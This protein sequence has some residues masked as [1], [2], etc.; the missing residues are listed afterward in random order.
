M[1]MDDLVVKNKLSGARCEQRADRDQQTRWVEGEWTQDDPVGV[2]SD[3]PARGSFQVWEM[4]GS[5]RIIKRR[6]QSRGGQADQD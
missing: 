3:V 5:R 4:G 1:R 6:G 2:F